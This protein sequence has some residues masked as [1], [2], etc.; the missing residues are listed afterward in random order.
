MRKSE[1]VIIGGGVVGASVAYHL[2]KR[3]AKDVVI[4]ER[5]TAQGFGS[6]GKATGGIR[7]Q[8]GTEINVKMSQYS[9]EFLS[10]CEFVT[11]Y[12]PRGYLFFATDADQFNYLQTN[13]KLQK[14][15]GVNDVEI[16][17]KKSISE[18][19]RGMNC[20]DI[21]GGSFCQSDGFINPIALMKGFTENAKDVRIE[22]VSE[23]LSIE[24]KGEKVIAVQTNNGRIEAQKVVICAGA[25]AK[26]LAKTCG[27]DLPIEPLRRQIVWAKAKEILP[28]NLPMVID[29]GTG[30]H[31][32]P[33]ID[34]LNPNE[35]DESHVFFAFPDRDE[36]VSFDTSFDE[37][38]IPKVI[39]KA[40]HRAK[41]LGEAQI[42][43]E[44][45]RAGLYE[46]TPDHHAILGGCEV[47][48]LYF[49]NGFSGHG[50]MHSP[51]TGRALSEII[52]D[53]KSSFLDVSSLSLERFKMGELLHE[54]AFI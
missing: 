50:V 13:V 35:T 11:G 20:E 31:F 53:G 26:S 43:R 15:L 2:S 7:Q 29:I 34:F 33:A 17:D 3:G 28:K 9:I 24:T 22:M 54:N 6:T 1:I 14:S 32:R 10:N 36:K 39:E 49:A 46:I 48:G 40:R 4:L 47:E 45:C 37:S 23:V 25:W 19:I 38:F 52:L 42:I 30:F 12:E 5:E 27:I 8:F 16:V 41:F 44:K 21:V 51:T 18:M